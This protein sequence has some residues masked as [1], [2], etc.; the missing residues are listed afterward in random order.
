MNRPQPYTLLTQTLS[1]LVRWR[2]KRARTRVSPFFSK[3]N[4]FAP[5]IS[6]KI[7]PK[8]PI[9]LH[10]AS[11]G[12]IVAAQPLIEALLTQNTPLFVTVWS[13]NGAIKLNQLFHETVPWS[14]LPWDTPGE[15]RRFIQW[16]K[17]KAL[18][19]LET[20]LW[21]NLLL[22]AAETGVPITYINGRLTEKSLRAP[23]FL[24]RAWN[25]GLQQ[26][27]TFLVR[28]KA[29]AQ[30]FIQLGAP[31]KHIHIAGNLK[32]L[33][34]ARLIEH[35]PIPLRTHPYLLFA[36]AYVEE[37]EALFNLLQE[38]RL[39]LPW[40]IV[41]R[42]P[43]DAD[44]M[45]QQAKAC[46]LN[47]YPVHT[48]TEAQNDAKILIETR[49]GNLT[50]WMAGAQGVIMGGSF[51]PYGGHNFLEAA[52][53]GKP[54]IVGTDMRDFAEETALFT[55]AHAIKQY[56]SLDEALTAAATLWHQPDKATALGTRSQTTLL[57]HIQQ[58][59]QAYWQALR[60]TEQAQNQHK[61]LISTKNV[62]K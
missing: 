35:P 12:E 20:E 31:A 16:L 5:E 40:V 36:S 47:P 18:W 10:C 50:R 52:A 59:R 4:F 42:R 24:K 33:A 32:W 38:Q 29:D 25:S 2:L 48:D 14:W 39:N 28:S 58:V 54:V 6:Q 56:E 55:T 23:A 7:P 1:P 43:K 62:V 44:T 3:S 30:R 34:A 45:A 19:V 37:T 53:L 26:V 49:F 22:N 46:D 15:T 61:A 51:A 21:P 57:Q 13:A 41:P 27:E 8:Q 11:A 17:P 9:W 60:L